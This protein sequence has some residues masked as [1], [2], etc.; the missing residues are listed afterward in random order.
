MLEVVL[1]AGGCA[2]VLEVLLRY[3]RLCWDAGG[4]AEVLEAVVRC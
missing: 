1:R 2:G 3:C 4:C